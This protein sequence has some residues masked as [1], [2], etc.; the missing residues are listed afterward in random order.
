MMGD[1][2]ND[3]RGEAH[4][5]PITHSIEPLL[6]L[7]QQVVISQQPQPQD[8]VQHGPTGSI[9]TVALAAS[10]PDHE[11]TVRCIVDPGIAHHHTG[12]FR[13]LR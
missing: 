5:A 12:K 13:G 3:A 9:A 7:R 10:I 11:M 8:A 6:L 1:R 4:N 2:Y